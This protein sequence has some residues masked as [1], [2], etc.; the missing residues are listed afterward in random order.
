[1]V[2][3]TS[4]PTRAF[5]RATSIAEGKIVREGP[6]APLWRPSCPKRCGAWPDRDGRLRAQLTNAH[7]P[8]SSAT[9]DRYLLFFSSAIPHFGQLPGLS[10]LTSGCIGQL[11]VSAISSPF[12]DASG[13]PVDELPVIARTQPARMVTNRRK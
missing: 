13:R 2:F 11:Y 8:G 5:I 10:D 4:R 9:T 12:A 1:M 3:N 6:S 7:A